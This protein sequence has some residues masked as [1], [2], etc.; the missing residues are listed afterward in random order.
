MEST[1]AL[2]FP[3][4]ASFPTTLASPA[5]RNQQ[6]ACVFAC[7]S[8]G[9]PVSLRVTST[10]GHPKKPKEGFRKR[11]DYGWRLYGAVLRRKGRLCAQCKKTRAATD[12][13]FKFRA[14][15]VYDVE[16]LLVPK[17]KTRTEDPGRDLHRVSKD[18]FPTAGELRSQIRT[19]LGNPSARQRRPV[20][21]NERFTSALCHGR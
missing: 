8:I 6:L 18:R 1:H 11:T 19:E 5:Q 12:S 15:R 14:S 3:Y 17:H 10:D 9:S 20:A 21:L 2:R 4:G 13:K 16:M 7:S